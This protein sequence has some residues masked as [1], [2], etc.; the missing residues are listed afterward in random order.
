M[1]PS[2][3]LPAWIQAWNDSRTNVMIQAALLALLTLTLAN[4]TKLAK[5][6]RAHRIIRNLFLIFVLIWEGWV[7]GGQLSIFHVINYMTAPS[8]HLGL[9]FYLAEPLI[10]MIAIYTGISL[11]LLGRGVFC[12]WL[13]PF[14]ALQEFLG[15]LS[16]F[17][18]LPQWNPPEGVQKY[19]WLGKYISAT[20]VLGIALVSLETGLRVAEVEPFNTA[21]T[22]HFTRAWPYVFYACA[23]LIIGLFTE[24]AYCRFL[25]PLGGLLALADRF[26]IIDLLKRRPECGSPCH[27]CEN[28]C[29]VKAISRTGQIKTAECFHCLDC[30]VEYHD[31]HRCP[32]LVAMRRRADRLGGSSIR[33]SAEAVL[34]PDKL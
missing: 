4:Q 1:P 10:V 29:P 16:R 34:P 33:L 23:L 20:L 27:L 3:P 25:C 22:S 28:S 30:Q 9:E 19:L 17:V 31:D 18:G 2:P 24:R 12:G 7:A 21:I 32:P 5:S 13:C 11:L 6:R 8:R 15:Q 26:H 14:G